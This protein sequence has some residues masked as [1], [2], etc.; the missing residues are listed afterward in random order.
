VRAEREYEDVEES[1]KKNK[2]KNND[3]NFP[4]KNQGDLGG[5]FGMSFQKELQMQKESGNM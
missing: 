1:V 2:G 4:N 3:L 5:V